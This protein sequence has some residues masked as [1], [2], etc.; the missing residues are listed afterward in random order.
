[1]PP[2]LTVDRERPRARTRT[3]MTPNMMFSD[4]PH[5]TSSRRLAAALL[6]AT[7]AGSALSGCDDRSPAQK[8]MVQA[9]RD[10]T[11][12]SG[13]SGPGSPDIEAKRRKDAS[14]ALTGAAEGSSPSE[15]AAMMTTL[16]HT[17]LG[18]STPAGAELVNI[19]RE[20]MYKDA[21]VRA[22]LGEWASRASL[23]ASIEGF[24]ASKAI[25][26]LEQ[27]IA[28]KRKEAIDFD[29]RKKELD[30]KI[31][32]LKRRADESDA[33]GAAAEGEYA[34]LH[35]QAQSLSAVQAEPLIAQAATFKRTSDEAH[36]AAARLMAESDMLSPA[37]AEAAQ[38]VERTANQIKGLEE[39]KQHLIDRMAQAKS[40]G[41]AARTEADAVAAKLDAAVQDL[42]T[43]RGQ[44]A[45]PAYQE[46]SKAF[47][48]AA[49]TAKKATEDKSGASKLALAAAQHAIG[50]LYW[51]RAKVD[52]QFALLMDRLANV[53]PELANKSAYA[54]DAKS[55]LEAKKAA[56]EQ[57]KNAYESAV[58]AYRASGAKGQ[59]K[60]QL[61]E[62]VKR[63]EVFAAAAAD[64]K[65]DLSAELARSGA[66]AADETPAP[67][68]EAA[69]APVESKPVEVAAGG[70][71]FSEA[72]DVL[73]QNLVK[74]ISAARNGD[75]DELRDV[76]IIPPDM[77]GT[78]DQ[79]LKIQSA[80]GDLE[81]A[82]RK[83][84]HKGLADALGPMAAG[85]GFLKAGQESD[86]A[87]ATFTMEDAETAIISYPGIPQPMTWKL[88]NDD[89]KMELGLDKLP[90]GTLDAI[91]KLADPMSAVFTEVAADVDADKLQSI[92]AVGVAIMQ[93]LGPMIQQMRQGGG[94]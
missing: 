65:L 32:D 41:H 94:G 56:L 35:D 81:R 91:V 48:A 23:A 63:L 90:A 30:S 89:W 43:Y 33:A 34:K 51:T 37:S 74:F 7:F 73:R 79:L 4:H 76:L 13:G 75:A 25:S 18:Q 93:K 10:I 27:S 53:T 45:D 31:A 80:Q 17:Q 72:P 2:V 46:L 84:F 68:P 92:E 49:S 36:I 12:M 71:S 67:T 47:T 9:S 60:E 54:D 29:A 66:P 3:R 70:R 62:V 69:P 61:D 21:T 28:T 52:Q 26:D 58:S 8:A 5:S 20:L 15:L 50:D 6:I 78:M 22:L 19:G 83:K 86:M 44:K 82:C 14:A 57:A 42:K 85:A 16:A 39:A 55:G 64:D 1:M 38:A 40:E 87:N 77:A 88:A 24:D 59:A 11:S